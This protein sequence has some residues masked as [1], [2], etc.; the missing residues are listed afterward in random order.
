MKKIKQQQ[1][2]IYP[3]KEQDF[4]NKSLRKKKKKKRITDAW[5][6]R[7]AK[8]KQQTIS[9]VGEAAEQPELWNTAGGIIKQ[10]SHFGHLFGNIY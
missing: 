4:K 8:I 3:G 1:K 7:M 2:T 9:S 10:R 6:T 5:T